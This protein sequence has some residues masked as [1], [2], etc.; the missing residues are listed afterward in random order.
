MAYDTD[1]SLEWLLSN[2]GRYPLLTPEEEL[3]LGRR[4]QEWMAIRSVEN[5]TPAQRKIARAGRRAYNRFFT[6]NIR[7]VVH[8]AK[9]LKA[10]SLKLEYVDMIQDGCIALAR[11]IELFDPTRG[12]KFSTYAYWWIRQGINRGIAE[13]DRTIRV[14][15]YVL[16]ILPKLKQWISDY[17]IHHGRQP[18][19]EE[20]AEEFDVSAPETMRRYLIAATDA[21]S[22]N[23]M[24]RPNEEDSN[25][26]IDLVGGDPAD[27]EEAH[28]IE[29]EIDRMLACIDQLDPAAV[30]VLFN[31]FG[32]N[33][34]RVPLTTAETGRA[35]G[36]TRHAVSKIQEQTLIQLRELMGVA[37]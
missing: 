11:A 23:C 28:E 7:L 18:S 36:I 6:G 2:A 19:I 25:E 14:P 9:K 16:E 17:Q 31:R 3:L 37:A 13:H 29:H 1:N 22:L 5:P 4:V 24:A 21:G 12:Y 32:L 26:L 8:L 27:A 35:L 10:R 20:L 34:D 15:S 33:E 30:E